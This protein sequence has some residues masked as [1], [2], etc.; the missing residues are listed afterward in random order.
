MIPIV[1]L[2]GGLSNWGNRLHVGLIKQQMRLLNGT[3]FLASFLAFGKEHLHSLFKS[4]G[5]VMLMR[6]STVAVKI[7]L[8]LRFYWQQNTH[9]LC[10]NFWLPFWF[11]ITIGIF[12][13]AVF[14]AILNI[15]LTFLLQILWTFFPNIFEMCKN[16]IKT[17]FLDSWFSSFW[18]I[19]YFGSFVRHTRKLPKFWSQ[20]K[21][22]F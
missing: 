5:G 21:R 9:E 3:L 6:G 18:H 7:R 19:F 11:C 20:F 1:Y 16:N 10:R 14:K 15:L 22:D 2:L 12:V 17:W 13:V 4:K 8:R